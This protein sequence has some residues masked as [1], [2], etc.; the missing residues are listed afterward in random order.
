[1]EM[2]DLQTTTAIIIEII[3]TIRVIIGPIKNKL[4]L[5]PEIFWLCIS[6]LHSDMIHIYTR[7]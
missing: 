2:S 1:M 5:Y 7:M 6:L 4:I 3:T